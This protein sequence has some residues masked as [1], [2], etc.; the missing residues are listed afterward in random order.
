MLADWARKQPA[1]VRVTHLP[2][3]VRPGDPLATAY[4]AP[5]ALGAH[6]AVHAATFDAIHRPGT[7]ARNAT[8]GALPAFHARPGVDGG[9]PAA[10]MQAPATARRLEAARQFLRSSGAEG[11]PTLVINGKY[12]VLGRT[13]GEMLQIAERLVEIERAP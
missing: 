8:R 7:L 3:P 2:A 10:A 5:H 4:F 12:R 11:T 13:L 6:D 1:D 9:Q